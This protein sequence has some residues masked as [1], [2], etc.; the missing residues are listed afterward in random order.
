M[1]AIGWWRQG[2]GGNR[3]RN[4]ALHAAYVAIAVW[5]V[6]WAVYQ[7][8]VGAIHSYRHERA[9]E[10]G[11]SLAIGDFLQG[12]E[13]PAPV[14]WAGFVD[15]AYLQ[16]DGHPASLFGE[17]RQHGWWY[18]FPV[19][20]ALKSSPPLVILAFLG[21]FLLWQQRQTFS[22]SNSYWLPAV[23]IA[24][25]LIPSMAST[26]NIGVRHV[27][28]IYPLLA[29]LG[30]VAFSATLRKPIRRRALRLVALALLGWHVLESALAHPDYLAYFTPPARSRDYLLLTDSNLD[31]G[32]DNARLAKFLEENP[33]EDIRVMV[34]GSVLNKVHLPKASQSPEWVVVSVNGL[35]WMKKTGRTDFPWLLE[36]QPSARIGRSILFFRSPKEDVRELPP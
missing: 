16:A 18:Y 26:V 10:Q 22:T 20:L 6:V 33:D 7:F 31:W 28:P 3:R 35:A 13:A 27:L 23:G 4:L 24:G 9:V 36:S 12:V 1:V 15:I 19:A 21:G 29:I 25:V 2:G 30:S 8:D 11:F 14:F 32:Q 34:H 5:L 17:S